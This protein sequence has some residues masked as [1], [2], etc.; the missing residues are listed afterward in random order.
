MRTKGM[1]M[2]ETIQNTITALDEKTLDRNSAVATLVS[3]ITNA[4]AGVFTTEDWAKIKTY[5]ERIVTDVE[6]GC[7]DTF[8][9]VASLDEARKLAEAGVPDFLD[10]IEIGAE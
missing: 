9:G 10:L 5:V 6:T 3:L 2:T 1:K 7:I 8:T 4:Y